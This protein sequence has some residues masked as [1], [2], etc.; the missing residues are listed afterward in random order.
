MVTVGDVRRFEP[1]VSSVE[2]LGIAPVSE[3]RAILTAFTRLPLAVA[4]RE[5]GEQSVTIVTDRGR[6]TVHLT[7]ADQ[8]GAA[9]V[10]NT[11]SPPHVGR[12]VS[13]PTSGGCGLMMRA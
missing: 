11:G 10:W 9:L 5:I 7:A 4:S 6:L 13:A 2:V 1:A 3:H 12:C 8:A